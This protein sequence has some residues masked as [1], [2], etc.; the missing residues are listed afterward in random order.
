MDL[1]E[2]KFVSMIRRS[3]PE[4]EVA[5]PDGEY[6]LGILRWEKVYITPSTIYGGLLHPPN[7]KIGYSTP[8]LFKTDQITP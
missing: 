4:E 3:G 6:A 1:K 7:Y 5:Y 8:K 2:K